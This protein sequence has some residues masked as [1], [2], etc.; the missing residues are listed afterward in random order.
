MKLDFGIKLAFAKHQALSSYDMKYVRNIF[1]QLV[2]F[3]LNCYY[4]I[5]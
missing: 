3:V 1:T 4:D 2:H 5:L